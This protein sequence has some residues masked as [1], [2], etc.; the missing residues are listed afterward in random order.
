MQS[1]PETVLK[2]HVFD[3]VSFRLEKN[4]ERVKGIVQYIGPPWETNDINSI[5]IGVKQKGDTKLAFIR[6]D[7]IIKRSNTMWSKFCNH[8]VSEEIYVK[9]ISQTCI[10]NAIWCG[11]LFDDY[12]K[13]NN[14]YNNTGNIRSDGGHTDCDKKCE[15]I[16]ETNLSSEYIDYKYVNNEMISKPK[17]DINSGDNLDTN[18]IDNSKTDEVKINDCHGLT[19]EKHEKYKKLL[20]DKNSGE[21]SIN[22]RTLQLNS[23]REQYNDYRE[24]N[25]ARK[26][27]AVRNYDEYGPKLIHGLEKAHNMCDQ[28]ETLAKTSGKNNE[29]LKETSERARVSYN[30]PITS[31]YCI[32]IYE[33]LLYNYN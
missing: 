22:K 20:F 6:F 2:V 30:F 4:G 14:K 28:M 18:S 31:I 7:Q 33:C 32:Y 16:Y 13:N 10:I 19:A 8:T 27:N 21:V 5:V 29:S 9:N 26:Q 17:I 25:D 3:R 12:T 1:E 11:Q 24:T 23:V 15:V